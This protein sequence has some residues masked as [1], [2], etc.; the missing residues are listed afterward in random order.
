MDKWWKNSVVYQVYPR[1]FMDADGD[2]FG[3]IPGV[4]QKLDYLK[5]LGIDVIWLSPV[6]DSPQDDNGYDI[7]DYR[8]VYDRFGTTGDLDVY[9]RQGLRNRG[10]DII[11]SQDTQE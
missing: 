4:I 10:L 7:R 2:G 6:F 8:K 3:D 5:N 9:K 11:L 1:S